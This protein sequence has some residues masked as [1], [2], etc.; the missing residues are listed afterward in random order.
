MRPRL[1]YP[2]GVLFLAATLQ[3][4]SQTIQINEFL[5]AN[6][7]NY[8]DNVDFD[9][10]SDWIELTNTSDETV[11]LDGYYLSDDPDNPLKWAIPKEAEILANGFLVFRADGFDTGPNQV[12]RRAF[13]PWREFTTS[14]YHTNFKLAEEGETVSLARVDTKRFGDQDIISL[15]SV[16]RFLDDG[17]NPGPLW[18]E[19]GFDDSHWSEGAAQLG[20][21]ESDENTVVNYGG[22]EDNKFPTTYFRAHFEEASPESLTNIELR[23]LADDGAVVFLNGVEVGRFR[24][25]PGVTNYLS[26]AADNSS[27]DEFDV[28]TLTPDQL[29]SGTNVIAVEVHQVDAD[30]SDISFDL[31]LVASRAPDQYEQIDEVTFGIQ[32][33]DVSYGRDASGEWTFFGEPSP[34]ATNARPGLT[35]PIATSTVTFEVP[36][37]FYLDEVDLH[38]ATEDQT[39]VV[40]Y[41][42]DGSWP[43][44]QSPVYE[45]PITIGAT[46]VVRARAF[47]P[48]RVPG[49]IATQT[50]FINAPVHEIPVIS[51]AVD[52]EVFFGESLGVYK[53][54]HKG[55]EAPLNLAYYDPNEELQFQVNAGAKIGGENIW[56]FAQKPLNIALRG[57][58]GDDAITYQLFPEQRM[59]SFSRFGLRNGGDNWNDAMLRDAITPRIMR[60]QMANDVEDYR[61]V[62]V[63]L[64]GRY[65][66]IHNL[67]SSLDSNY[68]ATRYQVDPD[69]YDHLEYGHI[70]SGA[71]TLGAKEG[72][73]DD[74][75]SLEAYAATND[76]TDPVHYAY[77]GSRM[78]MESFIDFVC[79][80]DF[81]YN[82]SWRHNREFWRARKDGAKWKWIVPDLDRG[83]NTFNQRSSLLD[84]F[85]RD[86]D[87]FGDLMANVTFRNKLAQRYAVHLSSTFHPDRI[88]D[89]VDEANAEILN[90]VPRHIERWLDEEGIPSLED[91]QEELDEIKEFARNRALHVYSDFQDNFDLPGTV[92]VTISVEPSDGGQILL[93]G[94]HLLPDYDSTIELLEGLPSDATAI[95]APGYEFVGWSTGESD[96]HIDVPTDTS[97]T[98]TA[99]FR[100]TDETVL[101][102]IIESDLTLEANSVYTAD[103]HVVVLQ[104][105]TLTIP[106]GVTLRLPP[107]G[108]LRVSGRLEMQGTELNPIRVESRHASER[109]G[110]IAIVDSESVSHLSHVVLRGGSLGSNPMLERGTISIVRSEVEMDH[111]DIDE[112]LNPIFGWESAVSLRSSRIRTVHT[113]D[114]INVKHGE[115]LVEDCTFPGNTERDTDAIDFDN[116]TNGIIRN[117]RIY[118]F[119]GPNSDGIDV[120]EGCVDLLVTGNRIFNNSDKGI[121][122]GQGS[123]VRIERN[124]IVGCAQ[125]IGIKDT[126]STAWIDHNTIVHCDFAVAVFE[127]NLG[128]GGGIAEITSSILSR[129]KDTPV[130][131]DSLSLLTVSDSLSDTLPLP[132]AR[133]L[134][135]NPEFT[136]PGIYD[137]SLAPGSPHQSL[138]AGYVYD[139]N[140]YP[141]HVPNVVVINEILS[142]SEGGAPDWIELHNTSSNPFDLSGWYLSDTKANLRKYEIA[143]GTVI[144]ANGYLV[145]Y[146]NETFGET[147]TDPGKHTLFALSE[148]GETVYLFGPGDGVLLDYLEEES[149]GPSPAGVTKGRHLKSTQTYNF[150]AMTE[151]TPGE[152]NGAPV[153]GPIV[154]SEIM[155]RPSQDGDAEYLE[156]TN[157]SNESV[158][159]YDPLKET[160]W[161]FTDGILYDF[162][163]AEPISIGPGQ[164]LL[165]VRNEAAFRSRFPN[166]PDSTPILSWQDSGLSNSGERIEL[167]RPGDVDALGVRQWVRIDRVTYGDSDLWPT[168]ADGNGLSLARL[169]ESGYGNDVA[170]WHADTPTPGTATSETSGYETWSTEQGIGLFQDDD[171]GDGIAN[172]LEYALGMEPGMLSVLPPSQFTLSD[173]GL[174]ISIAVAALRNDTNYRFEISPD[175]REWLPLE[176]KINGNTVSTKMRR[177]DGPAQFVRLAV[178]H[179]PRN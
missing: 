86:F 18:A 93:N 31:E 124:L 81:V 59:A 114:G 39:A 80:E 140:D 21:G 156:L 127:K 128:A 1:P 78:D 19:P 139:P 40:H 107:F 30:S 158:V 130:T 75:L 159:L 135:G 23:L 49:E 110:S 82:S 111:L 20:Y 71:V 137:F 136:D 104:G 89:I 76:L 6:V 141:F 51:L 99:T 34:G 68:F 178:D 25:R 177:T 97:R 85:E 142:H 57:K 63:Y 67:R 145:F 87:L 64:N 144:P 149:F 98:L 106:E 94:V 164:R 45:T 120:G 161:R 168:E 65:W 16:W 171:D 88:A 53:N 179:Q 150:V 103:S 44:S 154:I 109:W 174:E 160:P 79:I 52:P 125:G 113:G 153:V 38:L 157:I 90:E 133:N 32:T 166:V 33:P 170:N 7:T 50:Y 162:P 13:S 84:N 15:G 54:V 72:D 96:A 101:P 123:T 11:S 26:Y 17:S 92:D 74:Y 95:A 58:Y 5:A 48:D 22:D 73:M 27:E 29:R 131:V 12:F 35:D 165:L 46:T 62:V 2:L 143:D 3:L 148:N 37:G 138:G 55:R 152:P 69:N 47:A 70:T 176:M 8:P 28:I 146:E 151:P 175:L 112:S 10:Y 9:D 60:G 163:S 83:F 116:V 121:S 132:G 36:G 91:R 169:D 147:S 14:S 102:P 122:V 134:M 41:T 155:Y 24:M 117:N 118:A 129:S 173:N 56:R 108:D 66:G 4:Q 119:R 77:M 100:S 126:G 172:G 167:S 43:T 42:L 61:P 105:V 115:G